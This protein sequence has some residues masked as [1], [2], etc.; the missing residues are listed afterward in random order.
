MY[1]GGLWLQFL[2]CEY[3]LTYCLVYLFPKKKDYLLEQIV[4]IS[5]VPSLHSHF[6]PV[7]PK[8]YI[9]YLLNTFLKGKYLSE[10]NSSDASCITIIDAQ[11]SDFIT[12]ELCHVASFADDVKGCST[13]LI[14]MWTKYNE[15]SLFIK[16]RTWSQC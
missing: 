8:Y 16:M 13:H 1:Q 2:N 7:T 15:R 10:S 11:D 9:Y 3:C 4:E 14:T 6:T 12:I 5:S